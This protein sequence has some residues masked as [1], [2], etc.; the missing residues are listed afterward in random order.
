MSKKI[1]FFNKQNKKKTPI[2]NIDMSKTNK[3]TATNKNTVMAAPTAVPKR[4]GRRP[5]KILEAT[6][7][8]QT[9]IDPKTDKINDRPILCKLKFDPIKFN[10]GKKIQISNKM[11]VHISEESCSE[12]NSSEG[13]F[14]NDIPRDNACNKCNKNEKMLAMIKSKLDK[15]EQKDKIDKVNKIYSNKLNFV[16]VATGNKITI[17]KTNIKCFWDC[18]Q[19]N[20]LP[21]F[22]PELY[23]NGVY[24]VTGCFCSFNCALAYNLYYLKDSKVYQRKAL[25]YQ[26]YREM[27]D[28]NNDQIVEIKEAPPRE[29]LEDF[30]GEITVDDFRKKFIV[31]NKEYI[32]YTPPIK[33]ININVE[34]RNIDT[35]DNN[36]NDKDFVLKRYKPLTNKKSV[37]TSMKKSN[38]SD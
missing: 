2:K 35:N 9:T 30:G 29:I 16:S 7:I 32:L 33:I 1:D 25:V 11:N 31:L 20:S 3:N 8:D 12:N 6:T 10:A 23:H 5:K 36:G 38:N 28:I 26:L 27:Y 21:C 19:F 15:Y 18:N 34:E 14:R 13:I 24:H 4:R 22:L 17:K 37:I